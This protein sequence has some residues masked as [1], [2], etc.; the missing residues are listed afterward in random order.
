MSEQVFKVTDSPP[1]PRRLRQWARNQTLP[2]RQFECSESCLLVGNIWHYRRY[3]RN[4]QHAFRRYQLQGIGKAWPILFQ[5]QER[6]DERTYM[7]VC[8]KKRAP[9]LMQWQSATRWQEEGVTVLPISL[10]DQIRL[11][12][13]SLPV[14]DAN[15]PEV[16]MP[17]P[18]RPWGP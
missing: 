1:T 4:P 17:F 7:Y 15:G 2:V 10:G 6:A 14:V 9:Y 13:S 8:I 16:F 11:S 12:G 3:G 18:V 5:E